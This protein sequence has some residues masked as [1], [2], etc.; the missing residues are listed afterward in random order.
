[1]H[2]PR[3][4]GTERARRKRPHS[5]L[6][7]RSAGCAEPSLHASNEFSGWRTVS[8]FQC[9]T[10]F[11]T[12]FTVV[13]ALKLDHGNQV[14][15][16]TKGKPAERQGRKATGLRGPS[17]DSGVAALERRRLPRSAL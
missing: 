9:R 17:Y 10:V 16:Y 1:M 8:T 3:R 2:L 4:T 13:A 6:A 14:I 7:G 11:V 5:R 15:F 12:G